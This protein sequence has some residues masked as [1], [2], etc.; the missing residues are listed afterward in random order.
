MRT[1]IG[2]DEIRR[3]LREDDPE[4]REELWRWA[5]AVRKAY[6]GDAV[7]LRGLIEISNYCVRQ[8]LYCGIRRANAALPRYRMTADEILACARRADALGYGTVVL[9]SGEDDGLTAEWVAEVVREIKKATPLAVT[10][11]LGERTPAELAAWRR[12]PGQ[13]DT[14]YASRRLTPPFS[15][16]FTPCARAG[17][18]RDWTSW[19]N[20]VV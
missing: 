6:V 20:C 12:A 11:S 5:D 14:C 19:G 4:A 1:A 8:C 10:L 18:S 16:G 3:W 17:V 7:H 15:R 13:T 9:Q 2:A